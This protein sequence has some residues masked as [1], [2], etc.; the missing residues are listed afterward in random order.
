M[1][2]WPRTDCPFCDIPADRVLAAN[3]YAVGVLDAYPVSP[4]HCLV[5]TRRHVAGFFDLKPPEL[6]AMVELLGHIRCRIEATHAPQGYDIGVNVGVA[7]GQ[8]VPHAHMHLIPR[9]AGDVVE[10]IGGVRNVIPGRG[11]CDPPR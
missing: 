2:D 6:A 4:G 11:R 3:E 10:P 1:N 5:V 8:T 7:A 9:Y